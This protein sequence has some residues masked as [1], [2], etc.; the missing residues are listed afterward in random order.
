MKAKQNFSVR[1]SCATAIALALSACDGAREAPPT[2]GPP[3]VMV[4]T[5]LVRHEALLDIVDLVGQLE[6]E[7]SVMVKPEAE[8]TIASV[9]FEE[10]ARVDAG[11]LLFRLRA[12]EQEARLREA[13]ARL[14]L[15]QHD[16]ERA[17]SLRSTKTIA[18]SELDRAQ[19]NWQQAAAARDLAEVE[20]RRTEIR[21][22][23]KGVLG[24]R[25]VSPG[26]RV[27]R[28]TGLVSIQSV[29]RLRLIFAVP[30]IAL[31]LARVGV[32]VEVE[33]APLPGES[34]PGEVYFVS[35]ALNT[36]T[37]QL[38]LKAWVAN[39][40]GVLRPGLFAN[41]KMQIARREDALTVPETAVAYDA[42]GAHVWRVGGNDRAE[43]VEVEIGIRQHGRAEIRS[44]AIQGGDRIVSAGT[45]KVFAGATIVDTSAAETTS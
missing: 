40:R 19:S 8:G 24:A 38:L 7:E 37:R 41:I 45:H 5:E 3:P 43:R 27:D 4:E 2:G 16:Y 29:D 14:T 21:A 22:P 34:F 15:A 26:A 11:A 39:S 12:E 35:P 13:V 17:K 32:R 30:E 18:Q 20:L 1:W 33:V 25:L 9:E 44:G 31:P 28:E 23:F 10:G 6:S 36:Q 42:L